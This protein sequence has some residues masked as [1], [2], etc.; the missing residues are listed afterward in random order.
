MKQIHTQINENIL[1]L[2]EINATGHDWYNTTSIK[3]K[4]SNKTL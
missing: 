2:Q 3:D 4:S 1:F